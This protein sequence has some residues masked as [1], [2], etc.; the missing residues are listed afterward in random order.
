MGCFGFFTSLSL[1]ETAICMDWRV[2]ATIQKILS[3]LPRG[4]GDRL[5]RDLPSWLGRRD[6]HTIG[7]R[8][9]QIF[10]THSEPILKLGLPKNNFA[11]L[12]LGTGYN[13]YGAILFSLIGYQITTIDVSRDLNYSSVKKLIWD[14]SAHLDELAADP[15]CRLSTC[16]VR[17][18]HTR[19]KEAKTLDDI[20]TQASITYV[21]PYDLLA[22]SQANA[23]YFGYTFSHCVLEHIKPEVVIQV[24]NMLRKISDPQ[25]I[26]S[27]QV[28]MRDHRSSEGVLIDQRLSYLA[29]LTL[30]AK[31]WRFWNDNRIAY[32]N[33]W[34]KSDYL[35]ILQ[36]CGFRVLGIS[37]KV[38]EGNNLP[39]QILDLHPDFQCYTEADLRVM[40][41]LVY[42][43]IAQ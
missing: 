9:I 25:A 30:S 34:R 39:L 37:E 38:W 36:Q 16:E 23:G 35:S 12:E 14:L 10:R 7:T 28:D 42:G 13:L 15:I 31:Q 41:M 29:Y 11:I 4:I 27:H 26:Y 17:A 2:K 24:L 32:T 43:R 8:A 1:I 33:R 40:S 19:L 5:N 6:L 3:A 20:L 18:K 22:L 21:A